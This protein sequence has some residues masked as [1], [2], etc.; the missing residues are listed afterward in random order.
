MISDYFLS[1]G[2][3]LNQNPQKHLIP[4]PPSPH[5]PPPQRV[6]GRGRRT[7]VSQP[8]FSGLNFLSYGHFSGAPRVRALRRERQRK[9]E[10]RRQAS[11]AKRES[12]GRDKQQRRRFF[13]GRTTW[14]FC[15]GGEKIRNASRHQCKVKMS[16]SQNKSEQEQVRYFLH[17]T[18]N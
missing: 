16:G 1:S 10:S 5:P 9:R 17:K 2:A 6:Y 12:R 14:Q 15:S 7:L 8:I 11:A 13:V 4:F 3:F 18:C